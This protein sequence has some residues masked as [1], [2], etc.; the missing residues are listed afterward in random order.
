MNKGKNMTKKRRF[1]LD[2]KVSNEEKDTPELNA[3]VKLEWQQAVKFLQFKFMNLLNSLLT[4]GT[5]VHSQF[6]IVR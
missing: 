4:D 2:G 1:I 5:F 3:I 6:R